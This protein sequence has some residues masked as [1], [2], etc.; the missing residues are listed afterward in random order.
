MITKDKD[1]IYIIKIE[2]LYLGLVIQ[3]FYRQKKG[4]NIRLSK[5]EKGKLKKK[6]GIT[7]QIVE[8][9]VYLAGVVYYDGEK[10][11]KMSNGSVGHYSIPYDDF[12][13]LL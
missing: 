3:V 10:I 1:K 13:R 8:D 9:Y 12:L 4:Q 11:F 2:K 7:K 5:K 6:V